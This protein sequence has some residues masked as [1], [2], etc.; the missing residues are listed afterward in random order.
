MFE[1]EPEGD[2]ATRVTLTSEVELPRLLG[3]MAAGPMRAALE[4]PAAKTSRLWSLRATSGGAHRVRRLLAHRDARL[5]VVGQTLS[6]FGDRAMFLALGVWVKTLTGSNAAAG[7]VFFAYAAAG[8][9][10][11]ARSAS[12]STASASGR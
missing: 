12:S 5:L 7:L 1:L 9:D 4:A 10:L 6:V 11:A 2:H 3:A 8:P